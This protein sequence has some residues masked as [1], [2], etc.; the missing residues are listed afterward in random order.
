MPS[1]IPVQIASLHFPSLNQAR[2]F[3][4]DILHQYQPGQCV[5]EKDKQQVMNLM[6]SSNFPFP[7]HAESVICVVQA[8]YGKNCF[9]SVGADKLPHYVSIMHSLKRSA[10]E[11]NAS[12]MKK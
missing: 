4:R 5:S 9:A 8:Y 10:A 11:N 12:E 3:Y 1:S 6:T 7:A 2:I